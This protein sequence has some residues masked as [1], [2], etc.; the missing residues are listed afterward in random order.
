[1]VEVLRLDTRSGSLMLSAGILAKLHPSRTA[2]EAQSGQG[3]ILSC[4]YHS[5]S[6]GWIFCG[7]ASVFAHFEPHVAP[8][9]DVLAELVDHLT[10]ELAYRHGLVLDAVLFVLAIFFVELFHLAVDD[11]F[12]DGLGFS[13]RARLRLVDFALAI[14]DFPRDVFA[15][16]EPWIQGGHGDCPGLGTSL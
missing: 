1:M 5:A 11:L 14:E 9:R 12:D 6:G 8:D 15:A 13:C 2:L 7:C 10:D 3:V 16:D 4:R